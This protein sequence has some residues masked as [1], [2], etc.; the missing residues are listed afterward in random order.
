MKCMEA[1]AGHHWPYFPSCPRDPGG[2]SHSWLGLSL[3]GRTPL[4][5]QEEITSWSERPQYPS[6][7]FDLFLSLPCH[8]SLPALSATEATPWVSSENTDQP[9]TFSSLLG[10]L[11]LLRVFKCTIPTLK[12]FSLKTDLHSLTKHPYPRSWQIILF[13]RTSLEMRLSSSPLFPHF[14]QLP[15]FCCVRLLHHVTSL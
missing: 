3:C 12:S 7:H 14:A 1:R 11:N 13:L 8:T 5:V 4:S 9:F 2:S 15:E 10:C 6:F